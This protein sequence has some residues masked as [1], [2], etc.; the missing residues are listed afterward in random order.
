VTCSPERITG[1]VDD[2]LEPDERAELEAHLAGCAACR[3]Q[4][5]AERSLRERLRGLPAPEPPG[6]LEWRVRRVLKRERRSWARRLLPLAAGLV[7]FVFWARGFA[8]FVA[9]ELALD[10]AK[11][12]RNDRLPAKVFSEDPERVAGWFEERGTRLPVFPAHAGGLML[13]GGRY[14]PLA[15]GSFAAHIYYASEGDGHASLFVLSHGVRLNG[16]VTRRALGRSVHLAQG[17]GQVV[18]LV[19]EQRAHVDALRRALTTTLARAARY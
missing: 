3:A 15:D 8:P 5:A 2:A 13:V 10:H 18:A 6:D 1:H 9:W 16:A 11:C 14:C 4:A 7:L 19:S 12:F 17:E